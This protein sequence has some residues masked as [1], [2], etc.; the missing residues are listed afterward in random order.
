MCGG[1]PWAASGVYSANSSGRSRRRVSSWWHSSSLA[2]PSSVIPVLSGGRAPV[3]TRRSRSAR[4][5]K[6]TGR[7]FVRVDQ[8][9]LPQLAALVEVRD[10]GESVR[11]NNLADSELLRPGPATT[12]STRSRHGGRPRIV[13]TGVHA[14]FQG[15]L[16]AGVR[17]R[18]SGVLSGLPHRLFGVVTQ[19]FPASRP[20]A[21]DG[22]PEQVGHPGVRNRH[23]RA[24]NSL[25][26]SAHS[27]GTSASTLIRARTS[28]PRLVSWVVPAVSARG[29]SCWRAAI[30]AW[31]SSTPTENRFG[32][33]PTS[34]SE[35]SRAPAVEGSSPRRPWPSPC[36]RS[37]GSAAPG[38]TRRRTGSAPGRPSNSRQVR[39]MP[40]GG[41]EGPIDVARAP[42]AG[43]SGT[44]RSQPAVR[45]WPQ[46][47]RPARGRCSGS[48]V[49]HT[50]RAIRR[51]SRKPGSLGP[52]PVCWRA[53]GW[54]S[55]WHAR[56]ARPRA[57]SAGLS[58]AG[59]TST[60][61]IRA[62][63]S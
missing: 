20:G 59:S 39:T 30:R 12:A 61:S 25:S 57:R 58:P 37:A 52:R 54:A 1:R 43:R 31:K 11:V 27:C 5:V 18:P 45:R 10:A 38:R 6:S 42:R 48:R 9:L 26:A 13:E 46:P 8:A 17:G 40:A 33:P 56:A 35:V 60:R 21:H 22:L 4:A 36:P 15:L 50:S 34:F 51:R 41:L 55:R 62:M 24:S 19:A 44:P 16:V 23:Q 29:Q 2:A 47:G 53:P 49:A 14:G 3:R 32:L 28:S 63:A 7:R